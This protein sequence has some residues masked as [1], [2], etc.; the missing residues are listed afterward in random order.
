MRT[1]GRKS[2]G[3]VAGR[4]GPTTNLL[5]PTSPARQRHIPLSIESY[6]YLSSSPSKPAVSIWTISVDC[7][8]ARFSS[9]IRKLGLDHSRDLKVLLRILLALGCSASPPSNLL[10]Q[11]L[12]NH[13]LRDTSLSTS[14]IVI[15]ASCESARCDQ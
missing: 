12:C 11:E 2:V 10:C 4:T 15:H 5:L 7:P 3:L 13:G 8:T 9:P 1:G 6:L 14:S